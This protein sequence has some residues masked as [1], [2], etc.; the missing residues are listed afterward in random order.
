MALRF[1]KRSDGEY[2]LLT[3]REYQEKKD[4]PF[5]ILGGMLLLLCLG[6]YS[7]SMNI[8]N[9]SIISDW[10]LDTYLRN[11]IHFHSD[12]CVTFDYGDVYIFQEPI[13]D[14]EKA[15]QGIG[16]ISKVNT[17]TTLLYKGYQDVGKGEWD[18]IIAQSNGQALKGWTPRNLAHSAHPNK[19]G[20]QV[21]SRAG[22]GVYDEKCNFIEKK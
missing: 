22:F 18:A 19:I 6:I 17:S 7:I 12:K 14:Y 2:E 13:Q 21:F 10:G 9:I 5:L 3:E 4:A 16:S 15:K 20:E 8:K 11:I 1:N